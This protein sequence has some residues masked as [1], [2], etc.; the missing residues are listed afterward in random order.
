MCKWG[1]CTELTYDVVEALQRILYYVSRIHISH[2]FVL[3][4]HFDDEAIFWTSWSDFAWGGFI[5]NPLRVLTPIPVVCMY[6]A[7]IQ[8]HASN[9][10]PSLLCHKTPAWDYPWFPLGVPRPIPISTGQIDNL[11][12]DCSDQSQW[13]CLEAFPCPNCTNLPI[14]VLPGSPRSVSSLCTLLP[15]SLCKTAVQVK[16]QCQN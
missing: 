6:Q 2:C 1:Y 11:P 10:F 8:A 15:V 4:L 16:T 13:A 5:K 9:P 3:D 14:P 7:L 12:E